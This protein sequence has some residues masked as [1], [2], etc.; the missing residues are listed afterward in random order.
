MS[1]PAISTPGF[2]ARLL[3][4]I[5]AAYPATLTNAKI[6]LYKN[7]VTPDANMTLDTFE[8]ADFEGYESLPLVMSGPTVNDQ[9]V[10]VTKSNVCD[11]LADGG[12]P[13]QTIYGIFITN[14]LDTGLIAAQKFDIPQIMG[15]PYP[16]AINGVWRFSDPW[17]SY[18]WIDV[19]A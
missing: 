5:N 9:G 7:N 3:A 11:F 14:S 13:T 4:L 10:V 19:E 12:T 15:G 18:G 16:S 8:E 17:S 6:K 2:L 1:F